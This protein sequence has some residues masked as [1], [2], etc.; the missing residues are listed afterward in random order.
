MAIDTA[1]R[2]RSISGIPGPPLIAG[3]TSNPS[4][5]QEWRQ[6]SGWSYAG[7]LTGVAVVA[8]S[9]LRTLRIPQIHRRRKARP[10]FTDVLG[11][12]LLDEREAQ[13]QE[14]LLEEQ[15]QAELLEEERQQKEVAR[16]VHRVVDRQVSKALEVLRL[17]PSVETA[18]PNL[19]DLVKQEFK[20]SME[21]Q[22]RRSSRSL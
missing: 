13:V 15:R 12:A 19:Q 18:L 17:T 3:V 14:V 22:K 11:N 4:Q 9:I 6:E 5:D 7:I 21:K 8:E 10:H 16:H 20:R 1:E 2:R